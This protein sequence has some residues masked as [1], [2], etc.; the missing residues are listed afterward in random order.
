MIPL[1]LANLDEENVIKKV[2]GSSETKK[3]LEDTGFVVGANVR[4]VN[5]VG[6]NLIINIKEARVA[7]S[8][9]L[10]QKIMV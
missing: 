4:I 9:E 6:G 1:I 3:H 7:L 8:R 5:T 10:A 2:G